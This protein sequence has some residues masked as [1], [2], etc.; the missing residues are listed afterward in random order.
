MVLNVCTEFYVHRSN[1]SACRAQTD[2]HTHRRYQYITSS[3]N[4]GG[5]NSLLS[6]KCSLPHNP[7]RIIPRC[8]LFPRGFHLC[9]FAPFYQGGGGG[10]GGGRGGGSNL[11]HNPYRVIPRCSL[12][13][14][15]FHLCVFTPL[16]G[17]LYVPDSVV[18]HLALLIRVASVTQSRT[19]WWLAWHFESLSLS[20]WKIKGI[21]CYQP[22]SN[23]MG[24]L[25]KK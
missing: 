18:H 5:N 15:G 21:K 25:L 20:S 1:C 12:F 23:K 24:K 13:P 9:V 8:P 3:A 22:E 16:Y 10:G 2:T 6:K 4:M 7:Y 19:A 14:R 11:P 17:R